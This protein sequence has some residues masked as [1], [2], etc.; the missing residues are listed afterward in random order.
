MINKAHNHHYIAQVEQRLNAINP[1]ISKENQ[2]IYSFSVI[3]RE[4][5]EISLNHTNGIKIKDNLS[6]DDLF[7]FDV[8]DNSFRMNLESAF[9]QYEKRVGQF[10]ESLLQKI[11]NDNLDFKEEILS[12]FSLKILNIFRNP[13]CIKKT[14]NIMGELA[15]YQPVEKELQAIYKKLMTV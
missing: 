9:G 14:L 7:S 15:F 3:D 8:V 4:K 11:N 13:Y 12:I 10:T 2:R 1:D 6:D 5:Y